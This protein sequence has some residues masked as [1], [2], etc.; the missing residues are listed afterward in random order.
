MELL[1]LAILAGMLG[2]G[3]VIIALLIR[4]DRRQRDVDRYRARLMGQL[5]ATRVRGRGVVRETTIVKEMSLRPQPNY[6]YSR[7]A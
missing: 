3:A 5:S 7:E 4:H 2:F 1:P 6:E